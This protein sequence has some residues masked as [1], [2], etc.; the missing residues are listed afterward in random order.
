MSVAV[1]SQIRPADRADEEEAR[2]L[3][4]NRIRSHTNPFWLHILPRRALLN[5]AVSVT[6][7]QLGWPSS[8]LPP[9]GTG[10]VVACIESLAFEDVAQP[11]TLS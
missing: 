2:I 11:G 4:R 8:L 1:K 6:Q 10:R 5:P 3:H 9:P 7:G